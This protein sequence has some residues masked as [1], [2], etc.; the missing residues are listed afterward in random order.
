MKLANKKSAVKRK[1]A[2]SGRKWINN[3]IT[4]E[5]K[6]ASKETYESLIA[7]GWKFGYDSTNSKS[8]GKGCCGRMWIRN[9]KTFESK[10]IKK[11]DP[12]PDGWEKG[13]FQR[14]QF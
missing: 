1:K 6:F 11:I 13:K 7:L 10:S 3:P 4:H 8:F 9:P 5:N 2:L 12:I 14:K